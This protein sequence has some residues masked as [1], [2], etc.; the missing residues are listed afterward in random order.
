MIKIPEAKPELIGEYTD[1]KDLGRKIKI[2]LI[3]NF[4]NKKIVNK[5]TKYEIGFNKRGIEKLL[6]N[7]GATKLLCITAIEDIIINGTLYDVVIDNKKREAILA[8]YRFKTKVRVYKAVYEYR[9]TV[10]ELKNGKF[11]YSGTLDIKKPYNHAPLP[12]HFP[13]PPPHHLP[14]QA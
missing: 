3:S 2:F 5:E 8:W 13:N 7:C 6:Y 12:P 11:I 9:F 10:R 4:K 1:L 14:L